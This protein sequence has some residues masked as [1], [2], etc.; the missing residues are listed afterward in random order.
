M[1]NAQS[2]CDIETTQAAEHVFSARLCL[3]IVFELTAA[4]YEPDPEPRD[5]VVVFPV[6][7][8]PALH[9]GRELVEN[10]ICERG[11]A[12]FDAELR[13]LQSAE[14][15]FAPGWGGGDMRL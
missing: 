14:E 1:F 11:G 10:R 7:Q 6:L 2:L 15:S 13:E 3:G 9:G 8:M 12:G 4:P 5:H